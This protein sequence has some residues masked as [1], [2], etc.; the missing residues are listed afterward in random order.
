M[1]AAEKS[2]EQLDFVA[3]SQV[4]GGERHYTAQIHPSWDGP[5][6]THGGLLQAIAL[7][8]I[9]AEVNA[10]GKYQARSLSCHYLRPPRHGAV[11]VYVD[12]LRRGRRFASSRATMSQDGK[13]CVTVLATHSVREMKE[14]A[15]WSLPA[16]KATPPPP[17]SAPRVG[18]KEYLAAPNETWLAMPE[19]APRFFDQILLAPRFGS[20]P[21]RG[22]PVDLEKGTENGGWIATP[23]PQPIEA[24]WLAL[25]VDI[26]WPPVLQ[27]LTEPAMAPT[28]D[29]TTHIRADIPVEGLP[30][31]P[32]LIHNVTRAAIG[33]LSEADCY[34]FTANGSLLAQGRQLQLLQSI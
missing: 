30:D 23:Q 19:G 22:K 21:F 24:A 3:A 14:I 8:A 17:R 12:P 20:A 25:V 15:H 5:L 18:P 27:T 28:L 4:A 10:D 2:S 7:R 33:G 34:I 11:D 32:L 31:Q 1:D 29:L 6:T 13:P 16:P 26:L 9:D